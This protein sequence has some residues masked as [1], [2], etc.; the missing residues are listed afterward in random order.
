M[1]TEHRQASDGK[2]ASLRRLLSGTVAVSAAIAGLMIAFIPQAGATS[3]EYAFSPG[4]TLTFADGNV[5]SLTGTF[6]VNMA[7]PTLTQ[8]DITL[9]SAARRPELITPPALYFP[10]FVNSSS[11]IY[12]APLP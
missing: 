5:E 6:T 9:A 7:G 1:A 8:A 4:A 11:R 10:I 3:I 2:P 12:L